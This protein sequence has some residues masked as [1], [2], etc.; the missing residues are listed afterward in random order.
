MI[1]KP[2]KISA[3]EEW[4]GFECVNPS[5][6]LPILIAPISPE[7][8]D[9]QGVATIRLEDQQLTCPYCNTAAVYRTQQ[10][11]R[12]QAREKRKLN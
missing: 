3:G 1:D 4:I 2:E 12:F 7:M 11:R 5:C 10:A 6:G 8:L 9:V